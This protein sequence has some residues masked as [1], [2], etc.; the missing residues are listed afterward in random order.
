MVLHQPVDRHDARV[1]EA[2]RDLGLPEEAAAADR[3]T[4][5]AALDPLEGHLAVQLLVPG[6]VNLPQAPLGVEPQ[7][8]VARAARRSWQWG[9]RGGLGHAPADVFGLGE[10]LQ[11]QRRLRRE[12][13]PV[14][15]EGRVLSSLP[16][17]LQVQRQEFPQ[18]HVPRLGR[19]VGQVRLDLR[20][21]ASLPLRLET[22]ANGVDRA[23]LGRRQGS[24][25]GT[26]GVPHGCGSSWRQMMRMAS[27]LRA[28]VRREQS[29]I[30][31]ISSLP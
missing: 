9:M 23:D 30:P 10:D 27:S 19:A 3:I 7:R 18:E 8:E 15:L 24:G 29:S 17:V 1:L 31:A 25:R 26:S 11:E 22:V 6:H 20:A 2:P 16:A 12:A 28:T 5:V 21:R 4:Q 14:L 13:L